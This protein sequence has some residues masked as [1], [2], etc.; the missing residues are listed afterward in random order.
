MS[1]VIRAGFRK[2]KLPLIADFRPL[3]RISLIALVLNIV[4]RN[5]QASLNKLHFFSWALKSQKNMDYVNDLVNDK[6]KD[7]LVSWGIEP[8]LN[9]ALRIATAEE[10][11]EL[12]KGKY[13]LTTYGEKFA[14]NILADDDLFQVEKQFLLSI[15]KKNGTEQIIS[16]LTQKLLD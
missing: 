1:K 5:N 16:K 6:N 9:I 13:R 4:S 10:L 7:T 8:A 12:A 11:V 14:K 3:Y 15:G 2:R